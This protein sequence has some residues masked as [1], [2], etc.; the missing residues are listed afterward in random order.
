MYTWFIRAV[1]IFLTIIS[2]SSCGGGY[3]AKS[4][5][6]ADL[7][8][9]KKTDKLNEAIMLTS[10]NQQA[11]IE[12]GYLIG[13]EDL[14]DIE[15]Y[16]VEEVKKTCRVNSQGEIALPLV[17]ILA[18]KGL[19]TTE[20]EQ[21]IAKKLEKY[22]EETVVTVFVKEYKSK[23]ISVVGA[24][25][26]P[27][28][29]SVTGQRYLIDMLMMAGGLSNDSGNI[30]Y[31]IRPSLRD[32]PNS[33]AE[34][35][36][37]DLDD[38]LMKGNFALNIPV[39]AGDLINIPKGGVFFVDGAVKTPGAYTMRTK[40]T[41]VQAISMAHGIDSDAVLDDIRIFRENDKGE[42]EVI[43]ADYKAIRDGNKP[44]IL[45]AENDIII[46]P[47]SGVSVFFQKFFGTLGR[48]ATFGVTGTY[49]VF[50]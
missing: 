14:L 31:I 49:N 6:A 19:T 20:V 1:F 5:P 12:E 21:L 42:K 33:R 26:N 32:N 36:I 37:I 11:G 45:L 46:V 4:P 27:Q 25:K 28:I 10:A 34:T 47:K 2:I 8:N 15:A 43:I 44:D 30:C 9:Q 7:S 22:V 29:F 35:I 3:S 40:T 16:N 41:L 39:F 48:F 18:V 38:L 50:Q 24:V 13:P 23:R 17:G